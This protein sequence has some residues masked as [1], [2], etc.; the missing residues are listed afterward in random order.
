MDDRIWET[1]KTIA[2]TYYKF[3]PQ[4]DEITYPIINYYYLSSEPLFTSDNT[5]SDSRRSVVFVECFDH[6]NIQDLGK[7]VE[8]ALKDLGGILRNEEE[9]T[10]IKIQGMQY[11]FEFYSIKNN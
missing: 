3:V 2:P 8:T 5:Y 10:D 4:K 1:L 6:S 9:I 11:E 7:R